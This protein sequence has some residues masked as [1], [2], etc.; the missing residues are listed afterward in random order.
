MEKGNNCRYNAFITLF[1]FTIT[2]FL[3]LIKDND[4]VL[5][6]ELNDMIIKLSENINDNNY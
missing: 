6:N 3:T 4:L 5:L 2:P 1:Y